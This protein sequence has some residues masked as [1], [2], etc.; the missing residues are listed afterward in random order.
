MFTSH[1]LLTA[2]PRLQPRPLTLMF[3]GIYVPQLPGGKAGF[4]MD[5][6]RCPIFGHTVHCSELRNGCDK[7]GMRNSLSSF[8]IQ[9]LMKFLQF[10]IFLPPL[11]S[12]FSSIANPNKQHQSKVS[13]VTTSL[14]YLY[15]NSENTKRNLNGVWV[16]AFGRSEQSC[17]VRELWGIPLNVPCRLLFILF[18]FRD[19]E[20]AVPAPSHAGTNVDGSLLLHGCQWVKELLP[21][22]FQAHNAKV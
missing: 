20:L 19:A 3:C 10:I 15:F 21:Y 17:W 13:M 11:P 12:E 18:S 9:N 22:W 16:P 2:E 6:E 5:S 7:V 1:R 14:T 8:S 4:A